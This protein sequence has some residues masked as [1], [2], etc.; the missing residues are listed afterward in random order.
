MKPKVAFFSF[1][2]C[3]G[4]QLMFLNLED[5]L[6]DL[7]GGVDIVNF[8]EAMKEVLSDEYDVSFIEGSITRTEDLEEV[9]RLRDRSKIVVAFGACATIGGVNA[10]KNFQPLDD[11]RKYVYGD[12]WQK[13]DTIPTMAL[14]QA[15]KVDAK[16]FGCPPAKKEILEVTTA[17][18]LGKKPQIPDY[19]V[20]VECKLAENV[21]VFEKGM[22][23]VG[24]VTRA[25]CGAVCPTFGGQCI[26]CRGLVTDPNNNAEKNLLAERGLTVD[27]VLKEYRMFDGLS[28]ASK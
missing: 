3:E 14:E 23:C 19:P 21:C 4:C 27:D 9:K 26:G 16:I 22:V 6:L 15:I 24:P 5:E 17:L 13:Y 10:I 7:L 2:S 20:C 25:G 18:L 11:V 1:S 12:K 28:E 8:R